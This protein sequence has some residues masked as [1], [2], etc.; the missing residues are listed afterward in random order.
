MTVSKEKLEATT[1][2]IFRTGSAH[3]RHYQINKVIMGV[4]VD[5]YWVQLKG[6]KECYCNCPGF[7]RQ[8]YPKM[9]H[10]HVKMA[11]DFSERCE[12]E[13]ACY[14]IEGTGAEANIIYL[15]G[16]TKYERGRS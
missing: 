2:T 15:P 14:F 9:E 12:P 8:R 10:K 16:H 11:L 1:Y 6:S 13:D 5:E 7:Q 4:V 3:Q